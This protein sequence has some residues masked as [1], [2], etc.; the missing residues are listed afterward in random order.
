MENMQQQNTVLVQQNTVAL[1]QLET[2]RVST[3]AARVASETSQRQCLE[4]VGNF[5]NNVGP[6]SSSTHNSQEWSLESFLQHNP[7]KFDGKCSPD[8]A[9]QWMRDMERIY[10]AKRCPNENRLTF[11]EY[12]LS[13][14]VSHWWSNTRSLLDCCGI[15][16]SWEIF[17]KKFYTEYFPDTMRFAKEVKFLQLVQGNMNVSEYADRFKH[18]ICFHTFV[19]DEE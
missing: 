14:E 19:M 16:I 13:G 4:I 3:E 7:T 9:D 12:L 10:N 1:Q 11:S 2:A 18:L 17:K 5:R 8:A 6:S 15:Q